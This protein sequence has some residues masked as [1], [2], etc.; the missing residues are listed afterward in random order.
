MRIQTLFSLLIAMCSAWSLQAFAEIG[1]QSLDDIR[2]AATGALGAQGDA[3]V[4]AN[5]H[6][7]QCAQPLQAVASGAHTALV[8]CPDTPG[9]RLY[10][11]VRIHRD[12]NVVVL[13][14]PARAGVPIT[15]DQLVI[16]RRDIADAA[17]PPIADPAAA[18]GRSPAHALADGAALTSADLVQGPP[19]K[20][21]DPVVLLT[22]I[23]SVEVRVAG[24][25]LGVA[26]PGGVVAAENVESHRVVRGRLAAPGV[27]EVLQ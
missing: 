18:I 15:A 3:T 5:V 17:A 1:S 21:G 20:R 9:W 8:R 24:R 22:R 4:A 19:L 27:I 6:F 14:G 13:R 10:V 12:A 7:A 23:G 11:P 2:A 16:Q 26:L 25:A